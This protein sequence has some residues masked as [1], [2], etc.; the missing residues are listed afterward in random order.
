ME[1][2]NN[3]YELEKNQQM[4]SKSENI[5]TDNPPYNDSFAFEAA[6][7]SPQMTEEALEG[8]YEMDFSN[9]S[10][11]EID[12]IYQDATA[13]PANENYYY[14]AQP[15]QFEQSTQTGRPN[16][17]TAYSSYGYGATYAQNSPYFTAEPVPDKQNPSYHEV[18]AKRQKKGRA[19]RTFV[20]CLALI[21]GF[22]GTYSF[23]SYQAEQRMDKKLADIKAELN[24]AKVT[25]VQPTAPIQSTQSAEKEVTVAPI[26]SVIS[27]N[28]VSPVVAIAEQVAPS[29]VTITTTVNVKSANIFFEPQTQTFK[30]YGSGIL[31]KLEDDNLYVITNHHV[32]EN[33]NDIRVTFHDTES[34]PAE[35]VGYDS[36][37][38]LAVLKIDMT[39][40]K[41]KAIHLATFGD[42]TKLKV[43]QLA[44]AIGNPLGEGHDHTITAGVIS[45]V[46]RTLDIENIKDLEVIQTDAA[47]NPGNS[48]GALVNEFSEVIGI[49]TAKYLDVKVEGMGFAIPSSVAIPV[50]EKIMKNGNGDAAYAISDDRPFLGIG[51]SAIT[52]DIYAKTGVP[53]GVYVTKVYDGSAAAEAGVE[54]G[55]ILFS[56]NGTRIK[57]ANMLFDSIGKL[58][59]G[60]N[61]KI[62]LVRNDKVFEVEAVITSFGEVN[63]KNNNQLNQAPTKKENE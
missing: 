44:V 41:N 10:A 4:T 56:L 3:Q 16:Y 39:K 58:K 27:S 11:P 2:Q 14:Q 20:A 29:V 19:F 61:V 28:S 51:F 13:N 21:L 22:Y 57:D 43:G 32:I 53:F 36:R 47:I 46:N 1:K 48:G 25:P 35:V 31:Y 55:D 37:N 49:N 63:A 26:P 17:Q 52:S 45:S 62:G 30:N 7:N 5:A 15:A 34:A 23:G 59:L 12:P 33:G 24:N 54:E 42:S 60:E 8:S 38:D 6:A 9:N 50:V 18:K 40:V